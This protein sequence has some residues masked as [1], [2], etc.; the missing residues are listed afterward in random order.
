M[1]CVVVDQI[2]FL[3]VMDRL[4]SESGRLTSE[5]SNVGS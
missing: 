5:R 4:R 2:P 1:R 3:K